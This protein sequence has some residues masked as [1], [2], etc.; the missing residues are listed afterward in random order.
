MQTCE[1]RAGRSQCRTWKPSWQYSVQGTPNHVHL[2]PRLQS[3]KDF[4]LQGTVSLCV[5]IFQKVGLRNTVV[6]AC[7]LGKVA[8]TLGI[9]TCHPF[10]PALHF[11]PSAA[12]AAGGWG[13]WGGTLSTSVPATPTPCRRRAF[14]GHGGLW[15]ADLPSP[16]P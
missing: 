8:I 9:K 12:R 11:R 16:S 6:C 2:Y 5:C 1:V 7:A 4:H 15:L 14:Q 10:F 13:G 3:Q